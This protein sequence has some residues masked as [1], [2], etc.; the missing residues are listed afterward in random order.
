MAMAMQAAR[1]H[2]KNVSGSSLG[3]RD[4]SAP[5]A[6]DTMQHRDGVH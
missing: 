3:A 1:A 2:L 6:K 4:Y 5:S